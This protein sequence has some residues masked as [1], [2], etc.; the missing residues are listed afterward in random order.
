MAAPD[1]IADASET[2]R[3]GLASHLGGPAP[4]AD[5]LVFDLKDPPTP[6]RPVVTVCLWEIA[7]D[8]SVRNRPPTQVQNGAKW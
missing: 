8:P 4:L 6:N 7:E 2:L 1:V 3:A 5:V